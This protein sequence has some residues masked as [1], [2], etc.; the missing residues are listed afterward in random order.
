MLH[1]ILIVLGMATLIALGLRLSEVTPKNGDWDRTGESQ[2][3]L[4]FAPLTAEDRPTGG[5]CP[6]ERRWCGR[7]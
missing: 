2:G 4:G 3:G 5:A 7:I 1:R 6:D